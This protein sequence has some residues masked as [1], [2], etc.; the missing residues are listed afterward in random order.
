VK[1]YEKRKDGNLAWKSSAAFPGLLN[2]PFISGYIAICLSWLSLDGMHQPDA[3]GEMR[4]VEL[5]RMPWC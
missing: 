2:L 3:D 4:P 1:G 5:L